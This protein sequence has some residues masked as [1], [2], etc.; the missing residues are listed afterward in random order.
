MGAIEVYS[1]K[2]YR[3]VFATADQNNSYIF[4][5][6]SQHPYP[7]EPYRSETYAIGYL[8]KG[9]IEIHAGLTKRIVHSPAVITLAP[10][11][12]RS[13]ARN[14]DRI[15]LD[16]IFF[17]ESFFMENQANVFFLM[18]YPFFENNEEHTLKL[19]TGNH[20]RIDTIF[21]L[22]ADKVNTASPHEADI[23][24]SYLY[25]LIHEIDAAHILEGTK[26]TT[27][28]PNNALFSRFR[29]LLTAEFLRER[30]VA[31]YAA[32][33]NVTSK[34]LSFV[35]KKHT[36]KT[37]GEL[38]DEAVILE[39]KVM[40]QN[41]ALTISQISNELNFSDQSVFG[42]FFKSN[43]GFSPVEYRKNMGILTYRPL[44]VL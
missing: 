39:C 8:K 17:K 25:V 16:I 9:S 37:A 11:V 23:I 31:F 42:K 13:F 7:E 10:T 33:L 18:K 35:V 21:K 12:V 6:V 26:P 41:T 38:I 27:K 30:S 24:R 36:G 4:I 44:P 1:L 3:N 29:K 15:Q 28:E 22:I 19:D 5:H 2:K 43:T 20:E 40:L 32:S 14:S 34:H